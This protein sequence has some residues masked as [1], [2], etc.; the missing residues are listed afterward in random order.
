MQFEQIIYD[1]NNPFASEEDVDQVIQLGKQL[2][3][4]GINV[5]A[6][7]VKKVARELQNKALIIQSNAGSLD[8]NDLI[9]TK[10]FAMKELIK[11]G[12][13]EVVS[14]L[15]IGALRTNP[16]WCKIESLQLSKT[17]HSYEVLHGLRI[18]NTFIEEKEWKEILKISHQTG[19]DTVTIQEI[20]LNSISL[21]K[22]KL[23]NNIELSIQTSNKELYEKELKM[24]FETV[25]LSSD[26]IHP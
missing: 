14:T 17:A 13:N 25:N 6:F 8:G 24:Q 1:L 23:S 21:I 3:L 9:Q 2:P 18:P 10:V 11:V 20:H 15:N 26:L 19:V 5:P 22:Q 16:G 12:V 7:W 4:K